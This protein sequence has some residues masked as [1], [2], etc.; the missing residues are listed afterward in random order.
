MHPVKGR[1][2]CVDDNTDTSL[3]V[4]VMLGQSGYEVRSANSFAEGLRL[5]KSEGFDLYLL[6]NKLPDGTGLDLCRLLRKFTP[7][8]PVVFHTAAAYE[9]DKRH[10]LDAGADVYLTKPHGIDR[11]IDVVS[12]L[13][14]RRR[15][16]FST[17]A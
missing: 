9:A 15:E 5:A 7:R 6:D 8:I 16:A 11:L 12:C 14:N 4:S 17:G 1:I 13:I 2:L 3:M 10:G